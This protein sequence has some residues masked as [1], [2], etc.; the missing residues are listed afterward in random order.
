M[1]ADVHLLRKAIR[2]Y[3]CLHRKGIK[4]PINDKKRVRAVCEKNCSWYLWASGD[5]RSK[6][7]QIKRYTAKR[8][9]SGKWKV[10]AFTAQFIADKFLESFRADQGMNMKNFARVVQKGWNMTPHR[11]KLQRAKRIA[12]KVIYGDEEEQYKVLWDQTVPP[13]HVPEPVVDRK[14]VV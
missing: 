5:S 4:L 7:F 8:T 10:H 2:A 11:S 1:F 14:S 6:A 9:C 13:P 12:M 3:N